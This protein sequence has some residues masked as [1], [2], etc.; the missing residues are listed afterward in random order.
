MFKKLC[1]IL[2]ILVLG[3][4]TVYAESVG[5]I[6]PDLKVTDWNGNSQSISKYKGKVILL[7]FW[8]SWCGPCVRSLPKTYRLYQKYGNKGLIIFAVGLGGKYRDKSMLKRKG[9]TFHVMVDG[10][11]YRS[12]ITSNFKFRGIPHEL[13][14]SRSGKILFK[15]HPYRLKE[16]LIKSALNNSRGSYNNNNNS[17]S[18]NQSTS[19]GESD[20]EKFKYIYNTVKNSVTSYADYNGSARRYKRYLN[21]YIKKASRIRYAKYSLTYLEKYISWG[22]Y[23]PKWQV[24]RSKW[25]RKVYKSKTYAELSKRVIELMENIDYNKGVNKSYWRRRRRTFKKYMDYFRK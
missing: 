9:Y 5:D 2:I 24:I 25:R 16:S 19:T 11:S 8:A 4:S 17:N 13:L 15:G 1:I 3:L 23:K 12:Q 22:I 18:N 14:I 6:A 10:R 21:Y 20:V 7:K